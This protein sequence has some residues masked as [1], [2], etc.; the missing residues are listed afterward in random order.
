MIIIPDEILDRIIKLRFE[1][2]RTLQSLSDEFGYSIN[3][4]NT[5]LK[6]YK[7]SLENEKEKAEEHEKMKEINALRKE[8]A[9][10]DKEIEFLKK[11]AA[12]FAK[13]SQ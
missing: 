2:G 8:L 5:R 1:E 6:N 3:V 4:I 12:F 10:K 13:E 11:A 9:E 7:K